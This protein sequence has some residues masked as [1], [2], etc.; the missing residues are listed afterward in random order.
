MQN[1]ITQK[2]L[3]S[4]YK[5]CDIPVKEYSYEEWATFESKLWGT[6]QFAE[7]S[8]G[9]FYRTG[10]KKK[11]SKIVIY[12]DM[13]N[14]VKLPVFLHELQHWKC[15]DSQCKCWTSELNKEVHAHRYSLEYALE[16]KMWISLI[17][18]MCSLHLVQFYNSDCCIRNLYKKIANRIEK[19]KLWK[20]ALQGIK[21]AGFYNVEV[22]P[23]KRND[24]S[25][26][27]LCEALKKYHKKI[28]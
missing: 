18:S 28:S 26:I 22:Y 6:L 3:N 19:S 4:L 20:N 1:K 14:Y 2:Y 10:R 15:Y 5:N 9:C 25:K 21:K 13:P 23:G 12:K 17:S 27:S 24:F 7:A 8:Q 16:H 11:D